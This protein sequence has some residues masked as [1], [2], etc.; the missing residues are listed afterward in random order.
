MIVICEECGKKYQIDPDKIRGKQARFNCKGCGHVVTVSKP[1]EEPAPPPPPAP[2][3]APEPTRRMEPEAAPEEKKGKKKKKGKKEKK[4]KKAAGPKRL[5]LRSKMFL[6]FFLVPILC[7]AAAGW[8]YIHQLNALSSLI[9]EE[10]TRVVNEMAE[11]NIAEIARAVAN[12]CAIYLKTHPGLPETRFNDD[13]EFRKVAVQKVG[14]TG[15]T[16]LYELPGADKIWRT[17][18]HANPKI[19]GIDMTKL[20]K[21]LGK[22]F[23][24][25]WKVYS[26]VKKGK[27]SRGYYTWQ[28]KDKK[29]RDKFMVCTA[30]KGTPYIIAATTYLYEF[31]K[32]VQQMAAEAAHQTKKTQNI[33]LAIIG[34]TLVLIGVLVSFYGHRVTKRIQYLTDAAERISVGD[35]DMD[36]KAQSNDEIGDLGEA[37][38]RMQDS[39]RLSIE[40]LRRRR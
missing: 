12:E 27:E 1:A 31:T 13:P 33:L 30:V 3:S 11:R 6:L 9:N 37:I 24:G 40:R 35:L 23:P 18:A 2:A 28:D 19:I 32:P 8:L 15:Y 29:F 14:K 39:I 17:W 5:G 4:E 34:G 16:A 38:S 36:I 22:S 25:F 10:S 7:I 26:G 20:K 21:P